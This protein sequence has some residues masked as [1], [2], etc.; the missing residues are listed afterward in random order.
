MAE[1]ILKDQELFNCPVCLDLLKNPAT[2]SCGHSFCMDCISSCWILDDTDTV[3][4]CPQCRQTFNQRP[5]LNQNIVLAELV[6]RLKNIQLQASADCYPGPGDVECD[7]CTTRKHKAIKSCLVCLVSYC[8]THLR[9]HNELNPGKKHKLIDTTG[10][11]QEKICSRHDKLLEMFCRTD[12]QCICFMCTIDEH[13]GHDTVLATEEKTEKQ[14]ELEVKQMESQRRIQEK[15]DEL[16]ELGQAME[17]LKRSAQSAVRDS[18]RIVTELIASIEREWSEVTEVIKAQEKAELIQAERLRMRL[19][20]EIVQM[21]NKDAQL[22]QLLQTEDEIHFLQ[23]FQSL[24]GLPESEDIHRVFVKPLPS[25]EE[26]GESAAKL[27][28]QLQK[29]CQEGISKITGGVWEI[30]QK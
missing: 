22:A 19:E 11:L 9:L 1:A 24:C 23:S 10:R 25:F 30:R 16:Q 4:S 5:V 15:E 6:E 14:R 3:Y 26:V 27:K 20:Q 8:E 29:L 17:S 7:V 2:I 21:K 12:Q 18:E 13:K 28:E